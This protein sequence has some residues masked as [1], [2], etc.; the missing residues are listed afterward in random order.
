MDS[1]EQCEFV[2]V[3]GDGLELQKYVD[4]VSSDDAGAIATFSGVTRNEFRGKTVVKLEYEAYVPMAVAKLKEICQQIRGKWEVRK[5]AIAHRTGVVPV[6]HPSVIIAISSAHRKEALEATHWA[7][8]ELKATVP[9]WK[10]EFFDDGSVWKENEE[11]R[12][13]YGVQQK[14]QS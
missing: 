5:I 1:G 8:D 9:I 2:E 11:S 12:R 13:L 4:L 10:K 6:R 7:I 3:R 14:A